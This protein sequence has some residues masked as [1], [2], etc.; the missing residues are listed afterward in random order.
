LELLP[1][2]IRS[3]VLFQAP[4]ADAS[5]FP[6]TLWQNMKTAYLYRLEPFG[7]LLIYIFF[8]QAMRKN[9]F[10][11]ENIPELS[12]PEQNLILYLPSYQKNSIQRKFLLA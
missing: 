6:R 9:R 11:R 10:V 3:S 4:N 2:P 5:S 7:S 1:L 12:S 8:Y